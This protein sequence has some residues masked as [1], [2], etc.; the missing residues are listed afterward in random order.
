MQSLI[1]TNEKDVVRQQ[2]IRKTILLGLVLLA[3][4]GYLSMAQISPDAKGRVRPAKKV[5][6]EVKDTTK[7]KSKTAKDSANSPVI[8]SEITYS[9]DDSIPFDFEKK[10]AFLYK[11]G[12]VVY[13]DIQL[14]ADYI[15]M[16]MDKKEVFAH[17]VMNDSSKTIVGRPVF[18]DKSGEYE[19]DTLR[20]NFNTKKAIVFGILTEQS[21]GIIQGNKTKKTKDNEYCMVDGKYTTCDE[22]PPHFYLRLTKAKV[23]PKKVVVTGPAYLVLEDFPI[24]FPFLPFGYFPSTTSYSSGILIPTYGEET[25]RGFFLRDGGY[26]WAASDYY[27]AAVRAD[28]YSKGSWGVKMNSNYKLRYK[29]SGS[30][31]ISYADNI[32]GQEGLPSYSKSHDF[33]IMW[34]HSQDSKSNPSQTVSA[35]V[36]FSTSGYDR[37]NSYSAQKYLTNSKSS[38]VSF[39][40]KWDN[41]PFSMSM[42]L[43]HSQN[44]TDSTISLSLPEM[45][46]TMNRIYP[47]R[48]ANSYGTQHFWDKIGISYSGDYR[49]MANNVKENKVFDADSWESGAQHNTSLELPSFSLL[50]YFNF[51]PGINYSERWY[52]SYYTED[53]VPDA[54]YDRYSGRTSGAVEYI[55]HNAFKRT[56]DYS[57]SLSMNTQIYGIFNFTNPK[58]KVKAIRH[59]IKPSISFSY[60]PDFTGEN[61]GWMRSYQNDTAKVYYSIF[62]RSLYPYTPSGKTGAISFNLSNNIEMKVLNTNDTTSKEKYKKVPI[63]DN[64]NFS[65]NYNMMADSFKLSMISFSGRTKIH[66]TDINFSG[67]IDPYA[68]SGTRDINEYEFKKSGSLGHLRSFSTSYGMSFKSQ[69]ER[70]KEEKNK[71]QVEGKNTLP[72]YYSDYADFNVPWDLRFDYTFNYSRS[73]GM[74]SQVLQTLGLSGNINVTPKWKAT[75]TSG[76]DFKQGKISY[77]NVSVFRDLHCWQMSFNFTPFG[78]R[79]FYSF[80]INVKSSVL[81]DL[82][83]TKSQTWWDR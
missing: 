30:F 52:S 56:Y 57:Y 18:K 27:D 17:G 67:I 2:K 65:A 21:G 43:R 14:T 66:G 3:G 41:S 47:F 50:K 24:I 44:S 71:D 4:I 55:K 9:A 62:S 83:L 69:E 58:S 13:K 26:Y 15:E 37:N 77:T 25:Q 45:T 46:L 75:F 74:P 35:S 64:L 38:S 6:K 61:M 16:D 32:Y 78:Y 8:D 1:L 7:V 82:K 70:A 34:S 80:Q 42:N 19:A 28:I 51:S 33:A 5:K 79:S 29:F 60:H 54:N 31:A 73:P 63:L 23:I 81:R 72:A 68:T 22:D 39:T 53:W 10:K 12:K 11:N 59:L 48:K 20:Y 49:Y 40:K 36:N 76:Y